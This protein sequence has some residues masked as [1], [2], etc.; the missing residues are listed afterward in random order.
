MKK[1]LLFLTVAMLAVCFFAIGVSASDVYTASVDGQGPLFYLRG[2][3]INE[4]G[5]SICVE[6]DVN[7]EALEAYKAQAGDGFEYGVVFSLE[8]NLV[9]GKPLDAM[10][11]AVG[12][13]VYKAKLSEL[14]NSL[15]TLNVFIAL[16]LSL[17]SV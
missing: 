10:G 2:Y 3:A 12:E 9:N 4:A 15:I 7:L 13:K 5:G 17:N 14:E 8:G 11:N 1:F 6:Y 16:T